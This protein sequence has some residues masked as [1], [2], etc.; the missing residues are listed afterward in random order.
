MEWAA[1]VEAI[2]PGILI[3]VCGVRAAAC[4]KVGIGESHATDAGVRMRRAEGFAADCVDPFMQTD[5][6]WESF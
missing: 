6:V 2:G 5:G 4:A 3:M 1:A